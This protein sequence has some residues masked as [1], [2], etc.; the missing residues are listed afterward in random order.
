LSAAGNSV[1]RSTV[2]SYLSALVESFILYRVDRYDIKG[3]KLLETLDKFYAVD[4]G[5]AREILGKDTAIDR[6]HLLEN[7][8]FLELLRRENKVTV[9]KLRGGEVDSIATSKSG[10]TS[11]Y[12]VT[13]TMNGAETRER[14]L[15]PLDSIKDHNAKYVL[16]MDPGE[17]SYNGIKQLNIV[18]WLLDD[19]KTL[20]RI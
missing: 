1:N 18:D 20:T 16:T 19:A 13:E 11:Y 17:A 2:D 12:Q 10:E 4:V 3:K 14:E 7:V 8:V 9:G 15:K 6:G 5:L